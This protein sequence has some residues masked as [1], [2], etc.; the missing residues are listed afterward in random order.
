MNSGQQFSSDIADLLKQHGVLQEGHFLLTS[1]RH[2]GQYFEKFRILEH[3]ALCEVFARRIADHFRNSGVTVVCGPTTGGVIIAYEVA[4]QLG[5]RCV[6]AEKSPEGRK[7]GRGF[8][9]DRD[10]CVLVV[11]DVMTTGGSLLETIKALQPFLS[12][13]TGIAVYIDRSGGKVELGIPYFAVYTQAVESFAPESCP[14]CQSGIPLT[15]P[16]RSGK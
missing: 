16:G 3:P 1:G 15:V 5:C 8:R 12:T 2:S 6:I 10:D 9:L 7:I 11:D 13:L 4:R 14:L